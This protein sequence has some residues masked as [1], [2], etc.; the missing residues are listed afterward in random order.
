MNQSAYV[1]G[2]GDQFKGQSWTGDAQSDSFSDL[3]RGSGYLE[4]HTARSLS[5]ER[6]SL[7]LATN[8]DR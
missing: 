2:Y 7:R 1:E 6:F 8:A 4:L 5:N 3:V